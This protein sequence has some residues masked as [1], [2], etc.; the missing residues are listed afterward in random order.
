MNTAGIDVGHKTLVVVIRKNGKPK[1]ERTFENTPSGHQELLRALRA[2]RV[3]RIGLEATGVYHL[4]L[5]VALHTSN[6]FE[7]MVINPKAAK[8]YAQARMTRCKTDPVDAAMLAEFVEHMPFEPWKCPTE[9]KL[10]LRAATRRLAALTK[11]L[12]QAKNHLHAYQQTQF[13]PEFVTEDIELTVERLGQQIESMLTH[14][15]SLV[16]NDSGL[17]TIFDRLLTVKGIGS[18]SA[19]A[20]MGELLVL[21]E[22][23]SAKQWVAMAGLDPRQHQS[24]TSVDKPARISKAGNK[25]LRS[26]LYMP[27][28]SASRTEHNVHAYYQ[29]LIEQLHLKKIQAVCAVMRKLLHAIHGMLANQT[30]FDRLNEESEAQYNRATTELDRAYSCLE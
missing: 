20:L 3:T 13:T 2:A 25:Y 12:T 7:L 30:D 4:D 1:K 26:A 18:K 17:Q 21:P 22:D 24:G 8:H 19:I 6:H 16:E 29:H 10:A 15:L 23:M 11:L 27:A 28:L 5:A 14:V 9:S